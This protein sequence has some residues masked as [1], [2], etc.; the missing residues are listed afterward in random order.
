LW[1]QFTCKGLREKQEASL[2]ADNQ[3]LY[4]RANPHPTPSSPPLTN[5][6]LSYPTLW[7]THHGAITQ[8]TLNTTGHLMKSV[9]HI[10]RA[11]QAVKP[12]DMSARV[13]EWYVH[14]ATIHFKTLGSD[15][16]CCLKLKSSGYVT[17]CRLVTTHRRFDYLAIKMKALHSFETSET[18]QQL[19][20]A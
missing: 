2:A 5:L 13:Q 16:L 1:R 11:C 7:F 20:T 15:T 6:T 17:L 10:M 3:Y 9:D 12:L 4:V 18:I 19:D 14:K 8:Q